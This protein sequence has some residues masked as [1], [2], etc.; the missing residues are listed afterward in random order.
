MY[1]IEIFKAIIMYNQKV[2]SNS[3]K[4]WTARALARI[5]D[6]C[7]KKNI[8]FD[9]DLDWYREKLASQVCEVTGI[10]FSSDYWEVGDAGPWSPSIERVIPSLGY[11]KENCKVVCF[12]YNTAKHDFTHEDVLFLASVMV[13]DGFDMPLPDKENNIFSGYLLG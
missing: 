1:L 3:P 6:R 4:G 10:P 11:V 13:K 5:K 12:I 9:L 7:K 2:Y 8:S